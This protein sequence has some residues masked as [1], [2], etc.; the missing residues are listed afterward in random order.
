MT[1]M[2]MIATGLGV[3]ILAIIMVF[4]WELLANGRINVLLRHH[5]RVSQLSKLF[6][7]NAHFA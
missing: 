7:R 1:G 3:A 5:S 2:A 6:C 4:V